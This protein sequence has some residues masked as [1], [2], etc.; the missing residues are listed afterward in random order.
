MSK[1]SG[2]SFPA[3]RDLDNLSDADR[4][5]VCLMATLEEN[6]QQLEEGRNGRYGL[7]YVGSWL[8][9]QRTYP[10]TDIPI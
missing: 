1:K 2:V 9:S 7:A 10:G 8:G 4:Q 3:D 5:F 6:F